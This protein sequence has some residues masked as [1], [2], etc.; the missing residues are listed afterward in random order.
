M[1]RRPQHAAHARLLAQALL[2]ATDGIEHVGGQ[3]RTGALPAA[4]PLVGR[5]KQP[6]RFIPL[7]IEFGQ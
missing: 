2:D 3:Q 4:G 6:L 7:A 1:T 5:D